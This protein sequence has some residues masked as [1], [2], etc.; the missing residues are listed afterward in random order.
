[1]PVLVSLAGIAVAVIGLGG[2]AAPRTLTR[3]LGDWRM[4]TG[5]PVTFT[6]RMVFGFV[7]VVA[8][9]DCRLPSLVRLVGFVEFGGA[10][11]LLV[12]GAGRLE[13]FVRWWLQRPNSFVRSWCLAAV[14]LGILLLCAGG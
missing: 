9:P 1:M 14:A 13:R 10:A 3:I 2:V 8:A 6:L 7:F 11:G 12:L 4:L 5:L